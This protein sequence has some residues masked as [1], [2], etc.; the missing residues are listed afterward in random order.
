M[1]PS[2]QWWRSKTIWINILTLV[3][4][5]ISQIMG[6]EDM[7][8]YAPTLLIVSNAINLVLRFISTAPIK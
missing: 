3:A 7:K 4:V 1:T 8:S 6:W 2:K 5:I